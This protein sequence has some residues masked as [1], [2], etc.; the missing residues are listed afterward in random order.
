MYRSVRCALLAFCLVALAPGCRREGEAPRHAESGARLVIGVTALPSAANPLV[1]DYSRTA[2]V[3]DILYASLHTDGAD[4][5]IVPALAKRWAFSEDLRDIIF[6]IRDQAIW[7]DGTPISSAD[8]L[9]TLER[10][11]D[12]ASRARCASSVGLIQSVECPGEETVVFG[13]ANVF[14][15]QLRCTGFPVLPQHV[16]RG[17][18]DLSSPDLRWP[19]VSSGPFMLA[20]RE[21]GRFVELAA[22]PRHF[23]APPSVDAIVLWQAQDGEA[24]ARE[25]GLGHLDVV[26][27]LPPRYYEQLRSDGEILLHRHP[28]SSVI[29]LAWNLHD[30][31]VSSLDVRRALT[32][33]INRRQLVDGPLYGLGDV[34]HGPLP[35]T[36]WAAR[37]QQGRIPAF[38]TTAANSM[39]EQEGWRR[40]PRRRWREK[41]RRPLELT[42]LVDHAIPAGE[43]I[44][45]VVADQLAGVGVSLEIAVLEPDTLAQRLQDGTFTVALLERTV[46]S[47]FEPA[48]WW[49]SD[50]HLGCLN[51]GGYASASVDSLLQRIDRKLREEETAE[52]W[53]LLQQ[54]LLDDLPCTD[55]VEP[56]RIVAVNRRVR[57]F[58]GRDPNLYRQLDRCWIPRGERVTL[59]IA[60]LGM[61]PEEQIEAAP[62]PTPILTPPP[63][64]PR[65]EE[66]VE[67]AEPAV[68]ESD[69]AQTSTQ[70]GTS[71]PFHEPVVVDPRILTLAPAVYPTSA[72]PMRAQ[73][74]VEVEVL[75]GPDGQPRRTRI[76][77]SFGHPACERAAMEAAMASWF[78]PGTRDGVPREMW[79]RIPYN[80]RP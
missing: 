26:D 39:L 78:T 49:H 36:F 65:A 79:V 53:A 35:S 60:S 3:G 67:V 11:S 46:R 7:S 74:V 75:V 20:A 45:R 50:P 44:A 69:T 71:P 56:E 14:S 17:I 58:D 15:R 41:E 25:L 42:L 21:D 28:G 8:I 40:R 38:D 51:V 34:A 47:D 22:N 43:E 24:L 19:L 33:A 76:A 72:K 27:G 66:I 1:P 32:H 29:F 37:E 59:E 9:F 13:F 48:T 18:V 10:I 5:K 31:L 55:L 12:P 70:T 62:R 30:P 77:S 54:R 16:L 63:P 61:I 4:G 57:G 6:Q 80:F 64:L 23:G 73:G 52:E 2:D 68:L